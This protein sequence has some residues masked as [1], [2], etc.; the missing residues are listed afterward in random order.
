M[1]VSLEDLRSWKECVEEDLREW[2]EN[3]NELLRGDYVFRNDP[4]SVRRLQRHEVM[5]KKHG[6]S[7]DAVAYMGRWS[8]V[9]KF[10]TTEFVRWIEESMLTERVT[11][12]DWAVRQ[13]AVRQTERTQAEWEASGDPEMADLARLAD[14]LSRRDQMIFDAFS[15]GRGATEIAR[16]SGVSRTQVYRIVEAYESR[17]I[18]DMEQRLAES[19]AIAEAFVDVWEE[20]EVF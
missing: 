5:C 1:S 17:Q 9:R 8:D 3:K 14:L 12:A 4:V 11:L 18:A 13:R 15:K 20:E 2:R 10:C 6:V 16:V 19:A 7:G